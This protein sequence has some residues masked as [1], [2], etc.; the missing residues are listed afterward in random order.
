MKTRE[1]LEEALLE[2]LRQRQAQWIRASDD[3]RDEARQRF[4]AALKAFNNLVLYN[5][6]PEADGEPSKYHPEDAAESE[7]ATTDRS[8][9]TNT[10]WMKGF[11]IKRK[12][13][14]P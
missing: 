4:M 3:E 7:A 6:I 13:F 8:F 12:R 10:A 11:L 1:E 9:S 14:L 5:K 2:T